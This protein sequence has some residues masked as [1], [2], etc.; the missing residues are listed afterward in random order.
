MPGSVD[1]SGIERL[2]HPQLHQDP[3][4]ILLNQ[5][6][7]LPASW[8]PPA[9]VGA[10]ACPSCAELFSFPAPNAGRHPGAVFGSPC[11]ALPLSR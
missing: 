9:P 11:R 7:L 2:D 10:S 8:L 5:D 6:D 4:A 1:T 3:R